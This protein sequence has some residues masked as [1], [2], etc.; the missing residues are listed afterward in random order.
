MTCR[1]T[2]APSGPAPAVKL[3]LRLAQTVCGVVVRTVSLP[4]LKTMVH[5]LD[6]FAVLVRAL[7][8][9]CVPGQSVKG[10]MRA[11]VGPGNAERYCAIVP[12]SV[13]TEFTVIVLS[14]GPTNHPS[15]E[16][17]GW[18]LSS[19]E[20]MRLAVST[21][22]AAIWSAVA[23]TPVRRKRSTG[24]GVAPLMSE[25]AEAVTSETTLETA[26]RIS[27]TT[28]GRSDDV[29]AGSVP[30]RI[31]IVDV[32]LST[33]EGR[34]ITSVGRVALPPAVKVPFRPTGA[35]SVAQAAATTGTVSTV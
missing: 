9:Y 12:L 22:A 24:V 1:S 11:T 33:T 30:V 27:E 4:T 7:S 16:L 18:M 32:R 23:R 8:S 34:G 35:T 3:S 21:H 28:G 25:V 10:C 5:P 20:R 13:V 31:S 15:V 26:L 14:L 2:L 19:G 6:L 17:S 29:A